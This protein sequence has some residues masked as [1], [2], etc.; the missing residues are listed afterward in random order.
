MEYRQRFRRL[1]AYRL[2]KEEV[3]AHLKPVVEALELLRSLHGLR[4]YRPVEETVNRLLT[5]TRAHA[6]FV[7]RPW[8]EQALANVLRVAE[9]ARTYE[10]AAAIFVPRLRGA[11]ARGGRGRGAGGAHR[12]GGE[13]GRPHHDRAQGQGTGVPGGD[14]GRHHRAASPA[15]P[16]ASWIRRAGSARCGWVAGSRG[17]SSSTRATRWRG[18]APRACAWPTWPRR[19]RVTCWWSPRWATIRSPSDGTERP[20]AGSGR[21]IARSIHP[22]SDGSAAARRRAVPG[23]ARTACSSGRTATR[24]GATTSA[25]GC[26]RSA[27]TAPAT[28]SRGG[29]RGGSTSRSSRSTGCAA[30]T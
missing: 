15:I 5:A 7:L 14:P 20:T 10:A 8:G 19:E 12:G 26:T 23:S 3:E 13:R 9:L 24:R 17:I 11:P 29:I 28:A 4:N 16:A 27:R 18:I 30:T 2:P 6:A 21:S 25:R 1:H 22:P